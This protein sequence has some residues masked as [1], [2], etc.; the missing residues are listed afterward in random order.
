MVISS[1]GVKAQTDNAACSAEGY[2]LDDDTDEP[3]PFVNVYFMGTTVGTSTDVDGKYK[4]KTRHHKDTLVFSMLGYT[5]VKVFVESGKKYSMIIKLVEDSQTLDEVVITPGENP[6]HPILRS[7]I[8]NKYRNDPE[9]LN[10]YNCKT[11]TAINAS[12]SNITEENLK[13]FVPPAMVKKLPVK[14]NK[15]GK[16]ALPIYL[17][18]KISNNY[19]DNDNNISQM[20]RLSSNAKALMGFDKLEAKGYTNSLS[21][22][23]NFYKNYLD[24]FGNK[25]VSPLANSG[26]ATYRYYL[27]DST[28]VNGRTIYHIK[29][30]P[31]RDKELSF[32]GYFEVV[33][34]IWAITVIEADLPKTSNINFLN[35]FKISFTYDF[36]ND[37]S[38]FFKSNSIESSFH[39]MKNKDEE[40]SLMIDVDKV[41]LYSDIF[42]GEEASPIDDY[43]SEGVATL[44]SVALDSTFSS[45]RNQTSLQSFEEAS[46]TIDSTNNIPWVQRLEKVTNMFITGY[47]NVGKIDIGPYLGI[48]KTNSIEGNRIGLGLRTSEKFNPFYSVGGSLGYG[49]KDEEWKYSLFGEY[50]LKTENRTI[51]GASIVKDLYLFGVFSH[52][53]LIK[54]NMVSTG[55][56]SFIASIFKRHYSDRRAM[57]YRYHVYMEKEWR[58]GLTTNLSYEYDELREGVYVPFIHNGEPVEYIY[59]SAISLR[60]R[61]SWEENMTDIY[62]RRYYLNTNHPIINIVGTAGMYTV[63]GDRGEYFKLHLTLKHNVAVGVSKFYYVFETGH[64]FGSV[65]FP[66][67]NIVRGNDTYGNSRYRFNLLNNA[68]AA[69]DTYASVMTTYYFNGVIMNKI[70][71]IRALNIRALIT[72]KYIVGSLSDKHQQV[73]L[74]PWD[75]YIPGNQYLELGFGIE[76][77]FRLI[78]VDAIWRPVPQVYE[79]MPKYGIRVRFDLM[80]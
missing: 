18:E 6:A 79:G 66:L 26:L 60:T 48:F 76:N 4:I 51:F 64:I 19:I 24:L 5:E 9:N 44:S 58:L 65:P 13:F 55:E 67:L 73:L 27:E 71:V 77:I 30:V 78:R 43:T 40:T 57:L 21:A 2:V 7:I 31:R 29:F 12:L 75:M 20:Q 54:E 72:A 25:F 39:Y 68:T 38:L 80:M 34:D 28:V 33:K 45:Y 10:K 17:T 42:L 36:V 52:I 69:M 63:G 59:N 35:T 50:K 8:E 49:F 23:M 46:V 11:Y 22:E 41:T 74:Y 16:P 70:P 53:N 15:D 37:T 56:D 14:T 1:V 3:L 32:N 47:F 61:F 62:L